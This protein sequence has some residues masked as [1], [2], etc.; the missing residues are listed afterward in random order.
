MKLFEIIVSRPRLR[1]QMSQV[2]MTPLP[3]IHEMFDQIFTPVEP[4]IAVQSELQRKDDIY[5]S[6]EYTR[7]TNRLV[8]IGIEIDA[9]RISVKGMPEI[10]FVQATGHKNLWYEAS[11]LWYNDGFLTSQSARFGMNACGRFIVEAYDTNDVLIA[12]QTVIIYPQTMS[13]EQ[14]ETM[15]AEVR[16]LFRILD[17]RPAESENEREVLHSLFPLDA[18]E[19]HISDLRLALDEI[20]DAPMEGLKS[21]EVLLAPERIKRWTSKTLIEHERRKGQPKIR[22]D[23][24]SRHTNIPEHQMIRTMLESISELLK[25]AET[26]ETSKIFSLT[27]EESERRSK[28]GAPR[29]EGGVTEA[30]GRRHERTRK[31]LERFSKRTARLR[32]LIALMDSFLS[33]QLF[34]VFPM[35]IEET[36]IFIHDARYREVFE[37]YEN[38]QMLVPQLNPRKQAFIQQ[39]TNSPLLF[40]VWTLLQLCTELQELRF[41][42][43][44]HSITDL[45]FEYYERRMTLSGVE[46]NFYHPHTQDLIWLAYEREV[47]LQNNQK[48]KP[49]FLLSY[50]HSQ[51]QTRNVHVLDA[52]YKPYG[53]FPESVLQEDFNRSARRY[54]DDFINEGLPIKSATLIHSDVVSGAHHWNARLDGGLHT[55]SHFPIAPGQKEHLNTYIKRLL[56][57]HN[58]RHEV[59]PSC[60][61]VTEGIPTLKT[62]SDEAYKWT[63]ICTCDEVWVDNICKH[64]RHHTPSSLRNVRLLKYATG[65][66]NWQVGESWD[67]YCPVCDHSHSGHQYYPDLRGQREGEFYAF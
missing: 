60:G 13:F 56:H 7:R 51:T 33:T 24:A 36:H 62:N 35:E 58:N 14:Y 50:G 38:I 6:Q 17:T 44:D 11:D 59:C 3:S 5:R 48:R 65:N 26:I 27:H 34:E 57:H 52:K 41:K 49:D 10:S 15:Q 29:E 42:T 22:A 40:E 45:L 32:Q 1:S 23:V 8:Q 54:T 53:S 31:E 25:Q 2:Q 66:Y 21:S 9:A 46:L 47:F 55:Y 61:D 64:R 28:L 63:Y 43:K 20:I 12:Q 37:L 30:L 18:I 4:T 39:M 16:E 19:R 67:V